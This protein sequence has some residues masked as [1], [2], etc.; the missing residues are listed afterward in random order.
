MYATVV[1]DNFYLCGIC[2]QPNIGDKR[3]QALT[4]RDYSEKGYF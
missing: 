1:I 3:R 2:L 4:Q